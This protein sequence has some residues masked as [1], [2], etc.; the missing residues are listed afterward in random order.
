MKIIHELERHEKRNCDTFE[1]KLSNGDTVWIYD[2]LDGFGSIN[3]NRHD[4]ES[5]KSNITSKTRRA[6]DI[7]KLCGRQCKKRE[8][9]LIRWDDMNHSRTKIEVRHFYSKQ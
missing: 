1:V 7:S 3:I 2:N 8:I 5:K 4:R 6:T 9:E